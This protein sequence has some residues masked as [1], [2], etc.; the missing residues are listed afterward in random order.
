[1]YAT[2]E[3]A[4]QTEYR[5]IHMKITNFRHILSYNAYSHMKFVI[6]V[7]IIFTKCF[8]ISNFI[9]MYMYRFTKDVH[10][11]NFSKTNNYDFLVG[12]DVSNEDVVC[13][14]CFSRLLGLMFQS[15]V[16]LHVTQL[17]SISSCSNLSFDR[18]SS[19]PIL[20]SSAPL[21]LSLSLRDWVP[22]PYFIV[23]RSLQDV[24]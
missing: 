18:P 12:F 16:G 3:F 8:W 9:T 24:L 10:H 6:F 19:Y 15:I 20:Y 17:S 5:N 11:F 23:L 1:M 4:I 21:S 22:R 14:K 7:W 13:T 2:I